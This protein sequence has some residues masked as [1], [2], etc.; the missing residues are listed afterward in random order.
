MYSSTIVSICLCAGCCIYFYS[1]VR[2]RN[3]RM[4]KTKDWRIPRVKSRRP[5]SPRAKEGKSWNHLRND[6]LW[7]LN[8]WP[9]TNKEKRCRH[10]N[11]V[12]VA[13]FQFFFLFLLN[14][15]TSAA[16]RRSVYNVG[17]TQSLV[18]PSKKERFQLVT[19]SFFFGPFRIQF[20]LKL[21]SLSL[22][23]VQGRD[24]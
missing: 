2:I 7:N 17:N 16:G 24:I 5:N 13:Q 23:P 11:N 1:L 19:I 4:V 10:Y 20:V 3:G 9:I 12:V 21:L 14:N 22:W 8:L 15:S 6:T 18:S